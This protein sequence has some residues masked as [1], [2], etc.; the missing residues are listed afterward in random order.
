MKIV[1]KK[2]GFIFMANKLEFLKLKNNAIFQVEFESLYKTGLGVIEF[3]K[4]PQSSGGIA[5]VY[6]PNGTGKSTFANTIKKEART[7]DVYFEAKYN[8]GDLIVPESKAFF[9]VEDQINRNI[10]PGETSDYLVGKDIRKEYDLKKRLSEAFATAFEELSRRYKSE[11]KI[12]KISDFYL[13]KVEARHSVAYGFIRDIVN[14]SSKGKNIKH[15]EFVAFVKNNVEFAINETVDEDKYNFVVDN[16]SIVEELLAIDLNVGVSNSEAS[17]IEQNDDAIPILRKYNALHA[18]IVCDNQNYNAM[19][20]LTAKSRNRK[21]IY[22]S[23]DQVTRN[24]LDKIALNKALLNS[25]PFN[26][27]EVV[28]NFIT[29]GERDALVAVITEVAKF[30]TEVVSRMVVATHEIFK[31]KP[32]VRWYEEYSHLLKSQPELDSEELLYIEKIISENISRKVRVIRDEENDRNFKLMLD[33]QPLLNTSRENMHL[34]TGEQNFI[35][36][37]F[38]LLLA[39]NSQKE[40]VVLDDPISSFDSIYKNRIAFC[41]LK[42]LETKK[43]I[44]LSHNVDLVRLLEYQLNDCF[45]LYMLNNSDFGMNGFIPVKKEEKGILI[46]LH[47]MTS[48][49]QNKGEKLVPYIKNKRLFLMSMVPFM[50]G[51]AHIV[52]DEN[53]YYK[54]LS[55]LMHGFERTSLDLAEVYDD[56]FGYRF[57]TENVCVKDVLNLDCNNMEIVDSQQ[58]PLLSKTLKQ[59]L[60]YYHTRMLVEKELVDIFQIPIVEGERLLLTNILMKAFSVNHEDAQ[61][62]KD[63]FRDYR[64]FFTS[65][66]TLLNEFNHFEGNMNIFQPAIDIDDNALQL[67]VAKI[68]STLEELRK[69]YAS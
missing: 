27:K 16:S 67:E 5:V 46:N 48:L 39:R 44:I 19:E 7:N 63:A 15:E 57:E 54:K 13:K 2:G 53:D 61:E 14:R 31:E 20:L 47:E 34:S 60:V 37:A 50:R 25:D 41:I 8:D 4:L 3:K 17:I 32:V 45:N 33:D 24:M 42:F 23:L 69:N 6:A 38:A 43:Q 52:R 35:S 36:L 29:T 68:K 51:Y 30:V 26:I 28:F 11:F 59:T 22:D 65:R 58:Y 56:L 18:C 40:F 66:K 12:T 62:K 64:V 10:I 55:V 21:R 49:F 9:I 1:L